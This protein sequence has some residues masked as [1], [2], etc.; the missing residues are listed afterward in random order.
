MQNIKI[1][2]P[3]TC[4]SIHSHFPSFFKYRAAKK[5][6][7]KT[8][9]IVINMGRKLHYVIGI[10]CIAALL[11]CFA[12]VK[13]WNA[14]PD[15]H[16]VQEHENC[17]PL[18]TDELQLVFVPGF[19]TTTILVKDCKKFRRERVAVALNYFEKY[20][21][22]KFGADSRVRGMLRNLVIS[23][24]SEQKLVLGA[25]DMN[26]ALV[27]DAR[28]K[29]QVLTEQMIWVYVPGNERLCNTSLVHE[30]VHVS[31]WAQGFK[32]GDPDHLGRDYRG[33]TQAH[34]MLIQEVNQ[35]LCVLGI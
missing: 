12:C 16:L 29:G 2:S 22:E 25:Y 27:T 4:Q 7:F 3:M 20:W 5:L 15:P 19:E 10:A 35:T 32:M 23:F 34:N 14:L 13:S 8:L 6:V 11:F 28:L 17:D 1:K 33:W 31:L 26:G 30:L 21:Q 9:T 24:G 18:S